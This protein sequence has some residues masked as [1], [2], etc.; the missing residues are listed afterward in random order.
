MWERACS[1]MCRLGP[2]SEQIDRRRFVCWQRAARCGAAAAD[3]IH[4]WRCV[5]ALEQLEERVRRA[6][7]GGAAADRVDPQA[8]DAIRL[9]LYMGRLAFEGGAHVVHPDRQGD[10]ATKLAAA[11]AFRLIEARPDRGHVVAVVTGEPRILGVVGGTGL[12]G[13]VRTVHGKGATP[14]PFLDHIF[15][16]AVEDVGCATVNDALGNR[17]HLWLA[18]CRSRWGGC[19]CGRV[20]GGQRRAVRHCKCRGVGNRHRA[21]VVGRYARRV[22]FEQ[23]GA[24]TVLDLLDQVRRD[25]V[26]TVGEGAPARDDFHRRQGCSAQGQRQVVRQVLFVEAKAR[27]V[28]DRALD[29]QCLQQAD[30]DQVTRLVQRFAQTDRAQEGVGVV[31]RTPDLVQVLVDEHDGCVVDQAGG[32]EAVI[33]CRAIDER[34]EAGARLTLGLQ[35][36]VVVALLEG[37]ATD[38][39]TNR[40][41][42][43]VKRYQGALGNRDLAELQ[44]TVRLALQAHQVA[45]MGYVR[46]LFRRRTQAVGVQVWTRPLHGVPGNEFFFIAGAG[47]DVQAVLVDLA[48]DARLKTADRT[49]LE[50]F[51]YPAIASHACETAFRAAIAVALV[52]F[53]QAF[54]DGSVGVFLQIARHGSGDAEAFGIGFG[55]VTTDHFGTCHFGDVRRVHFRRWHVVAGVDRLGQRDLISALVDLAQFVHTPQNPVPSLFG[56]DRVGEWV[57]T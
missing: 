32:G 4:A 21:C 27:D 18:R 47:Q 29:T 51:L 43:R 5:F 42:L 50:Q 10:G 57:K 23:G 11:K 15:Q 13:D 26:A 48:D 34:L 39:R 36:A 3:F 52:V 44:R 20:R 19:R 14:R 22:G 54:L 9:G 33:Q 40:T 30:R 17:W 55:T 8:K 41:I 49:L 12:A 7:C 28:V 24:I 2:G 37:E 6:W 16:H 53:D 1:R 25:F 38:Q 56:A 46:R 31:L 45:H 35:G